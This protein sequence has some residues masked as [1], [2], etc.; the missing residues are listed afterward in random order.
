[1]LVQFLCWIKF[2][3]VWLFIVFIYFLNKREFHLR[4][5]VRHR[6]KQYKPWAKQAW[7]SRYKSII[8]AGLPLQEKS[9]NFLVIIVIISLFLT[10]LSAVCCVQRATR[11]KIIYLALFYWLLIYDNDDLQFF[12]LLITYLLMG[13]ASFWPDKYPHQRARAKN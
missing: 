11:K 10:T 4:A 1:M 13:A 12:P 2:L 6:K 7:S 5:L 9:R 8:C 3:C